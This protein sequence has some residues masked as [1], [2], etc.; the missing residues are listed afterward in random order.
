MNFLFRTDVHAADKN[1]VSWK[2]DYRSEV[3]G[4]LR[5]IGALAK[6]H[7]VCA[8]L[9]G[10]DFFHVKSPVKT[11]H[12]LVVEVIELHESEYPCDVF[13]VEGNHDIVGNNLETI[14]QQPLGVLYAAGTF[15]LLRDEIFERDGVKVRVVGVGYDKSLTLEAL[16]KIRKTDED[17]LIAVVH[18]L[19]S[20]NPPATVEEFF[21]EPV[22]RYDT[23]IFDRG[24]DV[25]LFGHWHRDQ[26]IVEIDGRYFV[27]QGAVSRGALVKENLERIP[28][29]ALIK[30]T[31]ER[32]EVESIPL[33]VL[34]ASEVFDL[35]AKAIQDTE[36]VVIDQFVQEL[37]TNF[38]SLDSEVGI[39]ETISAMNF[40][41]KVR[42]K[43]LAYLERVNG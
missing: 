28:K 36:S 23:L 3:M 20:E 43:A 19:A 27:N 16:Q 24:P 33:K 29:V 1:P 42:D 4:S 39:K 17:Y 30:A 14:D 15:K 11:S 21:G 18:A 8:V 12:S 38:E 10:G 2:A 7:K 25:F 40:A 26:G 37:N 35:E 41:H 31:K 9:D 5:Q 13:S 34:P 6:E 22:F 32:L